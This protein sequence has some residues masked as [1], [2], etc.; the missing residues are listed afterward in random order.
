LLVSR[1]TKPGGRGRKEEINNCFRGGGLGVPCVDLHRVW[2]SSKKKNGLHAHNCLERTGG[3]RGVQWLGGLSK[4]RA[5]PYEKI[6][7]SGAKSGDKAKEGE[8]SSG[9]S[10]QWGALEG[11]V[12]KK[13]VKTSGRSE[14]S[15]PGG[16][17]KGVR[18][19]GEQSCRGARFN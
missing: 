14:G 16:R 18:D 6:V 7:L 12:R 10:Q 13:A 9:A 11:C 3:P 1:E 4:Q 8:E 19:D 2:S 15:S 5:M 17:K